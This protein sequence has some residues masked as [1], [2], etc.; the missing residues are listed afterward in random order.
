[1][2]DQTAA[3][4]LRL[5]PGDTYFCIESADDRQVLVATTEQAGVTFGIADEEG[6]GSNT[7]LTPAQTTLAATELLR[8][9]GTNLAEFMIIGRDYPALHH[10]PA[11]SSESSMGHLVIFV[12]AG[13]VLSQIVQAAADHV[14]GADDE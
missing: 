5:L 4:D 10:I 11:G 3:P 14:C 6:D 13:D 7:T 9:T 8:I 1:M 12:S 2:T